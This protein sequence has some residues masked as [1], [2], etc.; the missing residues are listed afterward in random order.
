MT[1]GVQKPHCS[2]W[3]STNARWIGCSSPSRDKSSIVVTSRPSACRASM[4][5]LFTARP[6]SR[7]V[8]APHWLVSQPM[9][10]PV[11]PSPSRSACT[12]SVLSSTSSERSSPLTTSVSALDTGG[13]RGELL[14][15]VCE[16]GLRV[17]RGRAGQPLDRLLRRE[18]AAQGVEVVAEPGGELAELA[19]FQLRIEVGD[20]V[21]YRGPD[22]ERD[23]VPERV[24]REVADAALRPVD[25]LQHAVGV[26]RD[27]DAEEL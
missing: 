18:L 5:Q 11:S 2:P 13:Q 16:V 4:L 22:L 19:G 21:T 26:V 27:V 23:D 9:C 6:S 15:E 1:P 8:H 25:V 20:R 3:C 7:T 10:A 12:S 24:R 14:A 17:D